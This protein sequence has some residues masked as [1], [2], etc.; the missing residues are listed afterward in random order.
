MERKSKREVEEYQFR[1]LHRI[2]KLAYDH[3]S[4]YRKKYDEA[5]FSPDQLKSLKDINKIP[6]LTKGEVRNFSDS[7][8]L[9]LYSRDSLFIGN[10]SGTTG[11]ALKLYFDQKTDSREW[12]SIC[13]QWA[14]VGYKPGDG[15]VEFRGFIDK[16]LDYLHL[17]DVNV[18]RINIVKLSEDNL[19]KVIE[20]INSVGYKFLHGYPSALWKFATLVK[21]QGVKY[22]PQA[23]MM[24]SEILYDWQMQVIDEVFS[25][26]KTIHYGQAEKVALASWLS[27]RKYYFVPAYGILESNN[28][29]QELIAT[30][31]INEVMPFIRYKL[32]DCMTNVRYD[33]ADGGTF[34]P[35]A[36]SILGREED[37][38]YDQNGNMVPPAIV[39]FPF[40][41][42]KYIDSAKIVQVAIGEFKLILETK[43]DLNFLPLKTEIDEVVK[44]LTK[45]YGTK[46]H[47]DISLT[48]TI[49]VD[50]SGKFRWIECK[51]NA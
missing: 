44:N 25:C 36:D 2:V 1:Q 12:A 41:Q 23:I 39:T 27:D 31:L 8:V 15:R 4:F 21:R 17:P 13:Y 50:P 37:N 34:Y 46:T 19:S 10:T 45:I 32:T 48:D 6:V 42:L 24:A 40:K 16:D 35:I 33:N 18:L 22:Q 7:M 14:R 5:G 43:H 9:D 26:K 47:I 28:S 29:G 51:I 38:T 20:K 11:K 30:S 3:S 49:P